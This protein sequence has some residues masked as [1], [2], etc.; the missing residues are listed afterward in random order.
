[1]DDSY[2]VDCI[3]G[4]SN[5]RRPCFEVERRRVGID[6]LSLGRELHLRG[7]SARSFHQ[8]TCYHD[9]RIRRT[10]AC[11]REGW[12]PAARG[13]PLP[14]QQCPASSRDQYC[15]ADWPFVTPPTASFGRTIAV[16][17]SCQKPAMSVAPARMPT[18]A[19]AKS[20]VTT[21]PTRRQDVNDRSLFTRS[22]GCR[23]TPAT[24]CWRRRDA[25]G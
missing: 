23:P 10:F 4:C 16:S 7:S 8:S 25:R 1:M 12:H 22:S 20:R 11:R 21:I 13:W 18:P 24:V 14:R 3:I 6:P 19:E 5:G 17:S 9:C 2:T 15:R